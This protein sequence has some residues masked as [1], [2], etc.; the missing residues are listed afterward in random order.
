MVK[1]NSNRRQKVEIF[2]THTER[3]CNYADYKSLSL[4]DEILT[5]I[6]A[7][8]LLFHILDKLLHIE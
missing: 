7:H 5:Y 1:Y 6:Y 8:T 4:F 2:K 3:V